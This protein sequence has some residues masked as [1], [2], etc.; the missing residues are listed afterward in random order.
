MH[1]EAADAGTENRRETRRR[2]G[3]AGASVTK[4]RDARPLPWASRI[5][6][7]MVSDQSSKI[8]AAEAAPQ[9]A[10]T[11]PPK[12]RLTVYFDGSCPLCRLEIDHYAAQPGATGLA[13]IDVAAAHA[14]TGPDLARTAAMARF[15]VRLP[16]GRLVSGAQAFAQIWQRLPAWRHAARLARLPG[17][18]AV[19]EALYRMFLP[20][21]PLLSRLVGWWRR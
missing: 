9:Q 19:M 11:C 10:A 5:S 4:R 13:F 12:D 16:D 21:R 18:L 15:H 2:T 7:V 17:A 8:P 3:Q 20:V 1:H 14:D 6:S